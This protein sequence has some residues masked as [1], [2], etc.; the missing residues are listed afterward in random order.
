MGCR[1]RCGSEEPQ[2]TGSCS[3]SKEAVEPRQAVM[4]TIA[5]I[6]YRTTSNRLAVSLG[7]PH[8][9]LI[10]TH[11]CFKLTDRGQFEGP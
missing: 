7:K 9:F 3:K 1:G 5:P 2:A 8:G 4:A 6:T 10:G 11:F